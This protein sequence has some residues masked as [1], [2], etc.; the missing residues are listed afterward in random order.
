MERKEKGN[1]QFRK[2]NLQG[3]LAAYK[4]AGFPTT[5]LLNPEGRIVARNDALRGDVL[6]QTLA[7]FM[8]GR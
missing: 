8:P 7:L 6:A 1:E 5:F 3:A 2:G 4:I